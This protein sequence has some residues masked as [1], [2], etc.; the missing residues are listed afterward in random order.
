[1]DG[2]SLPKSSSPR[3]RGA[4]LWAGVA[5]AVPLAGAALAVSVDDYEEGPIRYSKTAPTDRVARLQARLDRGQTKLQR[6]PERGYL[7]SVLREL[8]IPASSQMLVFS[9]TSFQ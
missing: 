3:R 2:R 7:P 6:D 8:G 1:M 9:K 4:W 5:A